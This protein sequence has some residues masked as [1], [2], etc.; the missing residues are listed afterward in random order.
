MQEILLH[1]IHSIH[2]I[3]QEIKLIIGVNG[4]FWFELQTNE[5][6]IIIGADVKKVDS[7]S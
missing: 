4:C 6:C 3:L 7:L 5:K 2:S 1:L